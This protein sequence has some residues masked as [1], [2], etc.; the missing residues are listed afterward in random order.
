MENDA[1]TERLTKLISI[2]DVLCGQRPVLCVMRT[3][4]AKAAPF[5]CTSQA[6][7]PAALQAVCAKAPLNAAIA[8]VGA[9]P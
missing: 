2:S 5:L 6:Q 8:A 4:A 9:T 7:A 3:G 1:I